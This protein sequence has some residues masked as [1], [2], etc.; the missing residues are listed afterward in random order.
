MP[1]TGE[2]LQNVWLVCLVGLSVL[3]PSQVGPRLLASQLQPSA[4]CD[5]VVGDHQVPLNKLRPACVHSDMYFDL[6]L[7]RPL[8]VTLQLHYL[9]MHNR[10]CV[11]PAHHAEHLAEQ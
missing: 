8:V 3:G 5:S 2:A 4:A 6:L 7:A 1:T 10:A 11:R 9:V